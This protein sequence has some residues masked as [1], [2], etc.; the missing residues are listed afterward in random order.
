[1]VTQR[2]EIIKRDPSKADSVDLLSIM[3]NDSLFEN[4]DDKII[5]EALTFFFAGTIT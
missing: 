4:D 1:M 2:R 5:D 3:L